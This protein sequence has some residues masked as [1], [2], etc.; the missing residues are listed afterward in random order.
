M[1]KIFN[2]AGPCYADRHYMLSPLARLPRVR[3]L[4]EDGAYFVMHAPRQFGKTT[5]LQ[6]LA[7]SIDEQGER[8]ALYCSLEEAQGIADPAKGLAC[9][10][11]QIRS[12]MDVAPERFGNMTRGQL[13]AAVADADDTSK[14]RATLKVLS[15]RCGKPLVVLF[16]EVD[17]L[18][19]DTL[20]SFLRQL[21]NGR[22]TCRRPGTFPTSIGLV[23]VRNIR[24]LQEQIR[25]SAES[26]GSASPFNVITKVMTLRT[27]TLDEVRAL[28]EQHTAETGQAFE[29]GVVERA[30]AYSE[31]KPFLVNALARWCVDEIHD[32]R[33]NELI[34]LE[35]IFVAHERVLGGRH[36]QSV[37][38]KTTEMI[39]KRLVKSPNKCLTRINLG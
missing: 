39:S 13:R 37:R 31:G 21:R 12:A 8:V 22:I 18:G 38:R 2:I 11:D 15:E 25:P 23:G 35:D 1:G 34:T 36:T 10:V 20:V 19:E 3:R 24:E 26:L 16:D 6:A 28:Y 32:R 4:V 29:C 7:D 33:Y 5:A 30:F 27:F 14:V 9:V 17:C